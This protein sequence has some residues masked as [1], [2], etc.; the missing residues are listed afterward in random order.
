MKE[1]MQSMTSPFSTS[2][3]IITSPFYDCSNILATS[4]ALELKLKSLTYRR[5]DID[6][7]ADIPQILTN[8]PAQFSASPP[9]GSSPR[10]STAAPTPRYAKHN[11]IR[12]PANHYDAIAS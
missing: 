8:I 12:G 1:V 6:M 7:V 4:P 2:P 10:S 9:F 3:Y 11:T 5:L